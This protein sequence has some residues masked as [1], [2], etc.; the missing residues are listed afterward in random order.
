MGGVEVEVIEGGREL[1]IPEAL[2]EVVGETVV[3][4]VVLLVVVAVLEGAVLVVVFWGSLLPEV[5]GVVRVDVV[6]VDK[7]GGREVV[8]V[9]EGEGEGGSGGG[10]IAE[11]G[12]R[13][14]GDRG[15]G[16]VEICED[17]LLYRPGFLGYRHVLLCRPGALDVKQLRLDGAQLV[18]VRLLELPLLSGLGSGGNVRL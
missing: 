5:A 10:G 2:V 16:G 6:V 1:N 17:G 12:G 9:E 8:V 15:L 13:G 14:R 7:G 11:D 4:G 3:S 18:V